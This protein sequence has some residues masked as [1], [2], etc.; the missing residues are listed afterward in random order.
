MKLYNATLGLLPSCNSKVFN[1]A[2]KSLAVAAE[3]I[4]KRS[5]NNARDNLRTLMKIDPSQSHFQTIASYDGSYQQRGGKA[6]GGHS[7]YCFAAAISTETNQVISYGIACNSCPL[8][9]ESQNKLRHG[10][11][12]QSEFDIWNEKHKATCP[13]ECA[14]LSSVQLESAIAPYVVKQTL[15]REIIFSGLRC[16]GDTKTHE[17]LK[18]ADLYGDFAGVGDIQPFECL[19]HV[20]KRLKANLIK[21][22]EREMEQMRGDKAADV[23]KLTKRGISSKEIEKVVGPKYRGKLITQSGT[24]ES[25]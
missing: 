16:D 11:M 15:D 7:R 2:V 8:C 12:T 1:H 24:R 10:E 4:D 3:E 13:A 14:H 18:Q 21:K 23:R 22:H 5:K 25:W 19:A 6:G 20:C 17:A 9:T